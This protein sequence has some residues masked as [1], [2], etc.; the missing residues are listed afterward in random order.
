M[1][2]EGDEEGIAD[3]FFKAGC[4]RLTFAEYNGAVNGTCESSRLR[5]SGS[6]GREVTFG[7]AARFPFDPLLLSWL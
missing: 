3:E 4:T 1:T 5:T 2:E 6:V 7:L